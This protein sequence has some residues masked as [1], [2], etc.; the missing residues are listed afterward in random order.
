MNRL[1]LALFAF[2]T[3]AAP[4]H[5]WNARGHMMV[6]TIAWDRLSPDAR[7]KASALIKLNPHYAQWTEGAAD[8]DRDLVAFIKASVWADDIRSEAGY[9][10]GP[11]D[12]SPPA[13][14]YADRSRHSEWHYKNLAF[15]PDGT[16]IK[17]SPE[18][19][20]L[21]QIHRMTAQLRNPN[22]SAEARSYDLVWLLHLVGDVHQPLHATSRYTAEIPDGDRGGNE[23]SVCPTSCEDRSRSLH[24]F[25][26]GLMGSGSDLRDAINRSRRL[27]APASGV[28]GVTSP[29]A[30]LQ[31]SLELTKT[32]AYASPIGPGAGPY[33]LTAAYKQRAGDVAEERIA[34][35]GVRLAAL[36][37]QGLAE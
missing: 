7:A 37:E 10:N 8:A 13:I 31:E 9:S 30:W 34:L 19:N 11:E 23:V 17:A 25:W 4:A 27:A 35:A 1:A 5:A 16:P 32:A 18:S 36:I 6:A 22:V 24:S 2:L 33:V 26:D 15:S 12:T 29:D 28:A 14:G 21:S 3:C 20:A